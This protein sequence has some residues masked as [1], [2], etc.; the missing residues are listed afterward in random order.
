M[1]A[2]SPLVELTTRPQRALRHLGL[3]FL[4]RVLLPLMRRLVEVVIDAGPVL[5]RGVVVPRRPSLLLPRRVLAATWQ[6]V[7]HL[8][9]LV[10]HHLLSQHLVL[11]HRLLQDLFLELVLFE[12]GSLAPL[13][14]LAGLGVAAVVCGES[15][16]GQGQSRQT[17]I[18]EVLGLQ[19]KLGAS[20]LRVLH[21]MRVRALPLLSVEA[22]VEPR[23]LRQVLPLGLSLRQKGVLVVE[24]VLPINLILAQLVRGWVVAKC[25]WIDQQLVSFGLPWLPAKVWVADRRLQDRVQLWAPA[26]STERV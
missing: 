25:Q 22:L 11:Q 18:L 21:T 13:V 14:V 12:D 1:W 4:L 9:E 17:G 19:L 20:I 7:C 3:P 6:A 5:T 10:M 24:L 8:H 23:D 2:C 15:G 26:C 16:C